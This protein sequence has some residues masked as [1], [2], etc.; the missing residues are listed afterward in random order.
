MQMRILNAA[1]DIFARIG[2]TGCRMSDIAVKAGVNQALI[3]Y[4]F[5]SKEKLYRE[6]VTRLF[7]QWEQHVNEILLENESPQALLR[8]YIKEHF[9]LKCKLPNLHMLYHRESLEGGDLFQK[10]ASARWTGDTEEKSRMLADWIGSGAI[11]EQMNERV[12]LQLIWGM[13]NQFYYRSEDNLRDELK[14]IGSY[15]ELKD[16]LADQMIRMTLYGILPR[17]EAAGKE[18][19]DVSR[20]EAAKRVCVYLPP[21]IRSEGKVEME[22]LL[23]SLGL[24]HGMELKVHEREDDLLQA[25]DNEEPRLVLV[26]AATRF[27]EMPEAIRRLLVELEDNPRR[28]ADRFVAVWTA[29]GQPSGETLQRTLEEAFNRLGAFAVARVSGQN[30]REY[31]GRCAKFVEI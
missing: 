12:L 7:E 31:A 6:V 26:F 21:E 5:E 22:E 4:Y 3:H 1:E 11:Q 10:Y 28:I 8:K 19:R 23:D 2:F 16:L 24:L 17:D 29:R 30:G 18:N 9:E 14:M 20:G 15:E 13:M 25:L 27:G